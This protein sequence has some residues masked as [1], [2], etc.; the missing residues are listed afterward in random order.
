MT[1]IFVNPG[2]CGFDTIIEAK[3]SDDVI[4]LQINSECENV[5]R[6]ANTLTRFSLQDMRNA[7]SL[8]EN[9]VYKTA[10]RYIPH[11]SCPIPCAIF[12]AI[13]AELGWAEKKNISM[14]FVNEP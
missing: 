3:R 10:T 4:S 8:T 11:F 7:K 13:E 14:E 9:T 1:K 2:I 5:K 6:L 12:K